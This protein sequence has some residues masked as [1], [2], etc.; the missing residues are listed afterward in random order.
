MAIRFR[1]FIV[2]AAVMS[3]CSVTQVATQGFSAL[4]DSA[5]VAIV[6]PD[7]KHYRITAGGVS[8]AA[9]DWTETARQKFDLALAAY[10]A[11]NA[12]NIS[13]PDA[14]NIGDTLFEFTRLH[15]AVG[16]TIQH[17]HFGPTKMPSKRIGRS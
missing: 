13:V 15:A 17:Q 7:I 2:V 8:E 1:V 9:P 6:Q 10:V 3:G 14:E 5:R 11:Q 4:P 12:M 16:T